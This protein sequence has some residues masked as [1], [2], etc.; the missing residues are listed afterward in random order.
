MTNASYNPAKSTSYVFNI[1]N[2]KDLSFKLQTA[3]IGSVNLG[4]T[5][6]PGQKRDLVIPGNKLDFSPMTVRM[7]LSETLIEWIEVYEW[8][9]RICQTNPAHLEEEEAAEL[10]ILNSQNVPVVRVTYDNLFPLT[11]GE[12][13]Y[14]IVDDETTLVCDLVLSYDSIAIEHLPTNKKVVYAE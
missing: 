1:V 5:Q 4:A 14:S 2:H 7:L 11:L 10:L 8:M 12:V 3:S 13:F 6:Y 9:I